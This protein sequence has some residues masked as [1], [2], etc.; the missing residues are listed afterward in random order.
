MKR[1]AV[2]L[3]M[4]AVAVSGGVG[5][6]QAIFVASSTNANQTFT[7]AAVFNA[8]TVSLDD[9]GTPLRGTVQLS[10]TASSDG[11]IANVRFESAPAGTS[12][13]TERC[14]A[15]EAPFNCAWDTTA[16][17]DGSYD[18]RAV[19][20]DAA[21]Y[22]KIAAVTGRQVDNTGPTVTLTDPGTPLTG[23]RSLSATAGE[24]VTGV[25][26]EYRT[27]PA[28]AWAQ[29][30]N[31]TTAP[32]S[33]SWNTA[34]V[35]DGLYDL[36]ASASDALGNTSRSMV[37]ERRVD[38]HAPTVS[39]ANDATPK[40]GTVTLQA[41]LDDGA[42]S[43]IASVR[44]QYRRAGMGT[45][46]NACQATTE[47]FSCTWDTTVVADRLYDL[48][49]IATDNVNLSTTSAALANVRIDNTAPAT[50]TMNSVGSPLSGPVTLSGTATDSGSGIASVR[51]QH[52]RTGTTIWSDACTDISSPYS[53]S[54]DTTSAADGV[55]DL[56]ALATDAAGNTR[57]STTIASR[58]VDNFAP[59]IALDDPGTPLSGIRNLTVTAS[60]GGGIA[61]VVIQSKPTAGSTWT[62]ICTDTASPYSCP[63]DT[64]ALPDGSYDLRATATDNVNKTATSVV[65]AR[66]VG[67]GP[68]ASTVTSANSGAWGQL[69]AGDSLTLT[70]NE[71]PLAASLVAGWT[72]T[73]RPV[74]IAFAPSGGDTTITVTDTAGGVPVPIGSLTLEDSFTTPAG[75]TFAGTMTLTGSALRLTLSGTPTQGG[76][77]SATFL[78]TSRWTSSAAVTDAAGNPG[79]AVEVTGIGLL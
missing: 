73:S 74:S 11:P 35:A 27:S 58:R 72:G 25:M 78:P 42:G 24:A 76:V 22:S 59:A 19:A 69:S 2:L 1:L 61:S 48:R 36:R 18:L 30:C 46:T 15:T 45:W 9:P 71:A 28:G 29:I 33:C 8:V 47:P 77:Q 32:Y 68:R 12:T 39:I 65:A 3:V 41:L 52:A 49:A 62:T 75:A 70:Y 66:V 64:T 44:Y 4:L 40:S 60:D 5:R 56:R 55:Y 63:W 14:T 13:W 43:G 54:W 51:F 50:P 53:C 17:S 20:L 79:A 34:S 38:N 21:G 67:N 26:I 6:S 37:T 57:A 10:A 31:D 23:T 7:T 16:V